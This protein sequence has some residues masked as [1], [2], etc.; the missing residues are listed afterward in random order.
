MKI[1]AI[2]TSCDDTAASVLDNH[3]I[4]SNIISS[5]YFHSKYGGIVPELASRAHLNVISEIV[6]QALDKSNSNINEIEVIAVTTE[7][8]LH[9]SLVVGS[10]F[11]K[12][13]A[14]SNHKIIVPINHIEGHIYSALIDNRDLS[15]PFISLVVSG[16]HTALFKV[17]SYT[18]YELIGLTK[19]DAA[20]EAFDKIAKFIGLGYPGG[21][22]IDKLAKNGDPNKYNFPRPM[23]NEANFDFSFSGLKTSVRYFLQKH[24]DNNDF[25]NELNN[26]AASLQ[27]SIVDVLVNKSIKAAK[28]YGINSICVSGGVSANSRLRHKFHNSGDKYKVKSYF[29][30][31]EYCLDNAAMIGHLAYNKV[32]ENSSKFKALNFTVNSRPIRAPKKV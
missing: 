26:I 8:G 1:L 4:L 2:E 29:P 17:D 9:G 27:E 6:N 23:I 7:P 21:P 25:S 20:G 16:G 5:Q 15:F 22:I 24:F 19:D 10:N 14:L 28:H 32:M 31:L 12:G 30:N 11:A 18:N 13:L 3:I